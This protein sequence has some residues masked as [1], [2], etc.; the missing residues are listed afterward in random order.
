M[1][2]LTK[3]QCAA[4][5]SLE[6]VDGT[7]SPDRV[8]L[9]AQRPESAL[10][11]LWPVKGEDEWALDAKRAWARRIIGQY[12]VS[13]HVVE[14]KVCIRP[15]VNNVE[16]G[17][18]YISSATIRLEN[19]TTRARNT[20]LPEVRRARTILVNQINLGLYWGIDVRILQSLLT[21]LDHYLEW[22]SADPSEAH[23]ASYD[24]ATEHVSP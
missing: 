10:H 15:Y 20:M 12:K 19:D 22:L 9:E 8:V 1:S 17:N 4:I 7:L 2:T 11:K 13:V 6:E 3:D 14:R 5:K 23:Q 16:E 24:E 18:S 21:E